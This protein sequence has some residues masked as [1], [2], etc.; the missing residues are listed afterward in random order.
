MKESPCFGFQQI[1][2]KQKKKRWI[3]QYSISCKTYL[4]KADS[5]NQTEI[6]KGHSKAA[7]KCGN[8]KKK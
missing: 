4:T 3:P 2:V 8:R 5:N 1:L 6:A 7:I